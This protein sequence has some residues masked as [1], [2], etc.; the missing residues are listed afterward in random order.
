MFKA[1]FPKRYRINRNNLNGSFGVEPDVYPT[2]LH[3]I[4]FLI[5]DV[6]IVFVLNEMD[7]NFIIA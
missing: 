2:K 6:K 5:L 1:N 3:F 7:L 4:C